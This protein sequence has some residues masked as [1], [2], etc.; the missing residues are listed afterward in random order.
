MARMRQL[1]NAPAREA[2][3]D[4]RFEPPV[5]I[6]IIEQA[7]TQMGSKFEKSAPIWEAFVGLKLD[8]DGKHEATSN[9][10][11][12]GIR[13]D[14]IPPLHVIQ[15]QTNGFTFSRLHPYGRWEDLLDAAKEAWGVMVK[16]VPPLLVTRLAVRYINEIRLPLPMEDFSDYLE[17]LPE[18]PK[19]LPQAVSA[20]LQRVVIPDDQLKCVSIITQALEETSINMDSVT[21]VLDID[22]FRNARIESGNDGAIWEAM[23][24]LRTQKNRMFFEHITERTAEMYE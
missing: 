4:I 22:V 6:E 19:G 18:V 8:A 13:L 14:S 1:S 7:A 12:L 10:T 5:S 11:A 9:Q 3:I 15:Y 20:F 24:E 17:C 21:V 16:M 2:L 23:E